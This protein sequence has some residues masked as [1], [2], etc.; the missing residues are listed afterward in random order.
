MGPFN[1]LPIR[2]GNEYTHWQIISGL[3]VV[4]KKT[5]FLKRT[6]PILLPSRV[7]IRVGGREQYKF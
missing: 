3:K 1:Y 2:K 6:F 4:P 5:S 7:Q